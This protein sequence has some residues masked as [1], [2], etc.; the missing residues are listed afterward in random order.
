MLLHVAEEDEEE[1]SQN[2]KSVCG[3]E[4][5]HFTIGHTFVVGYFNNIN[6][7]GMKG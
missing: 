2:A 6:R 4:E 7:I 5:A 3:N 1:S